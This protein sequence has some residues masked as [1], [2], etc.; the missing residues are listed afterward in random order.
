M[1]EITLVSFDPLARS[2][3]FEAYGKRKTINGLGEFPSK[4]AFIEYLQS[5]AETDLKPTATLSD[6]PDMGEYVGQKLPSN[7]ELE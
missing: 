1:T 3:V 2:V 5:V 4:E 7:T 6:L